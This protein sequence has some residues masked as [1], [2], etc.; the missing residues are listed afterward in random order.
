MGRRRKG[1]T[2][3]IGALAWLAAEAGVAAPGWTLQPSASELR[4]AATQAG[5][6]FEGRFAG[7]EA[8]IRFDE[9]DLASSR[10]A[11]TVRT[12]T[13]ETGEARRDGILRAGTSSG[14]SAIRMRCS[15]R[16][17]SACRARAISRRARSRCAA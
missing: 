10:F 15:R 8:E 11:V 4:F 16:S 9:R 2:L 1:L 12:G 17:T 14:P 5:A 7:F 3:A 13:A 6:R